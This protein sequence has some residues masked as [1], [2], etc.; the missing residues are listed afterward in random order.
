MVDYFFANRMVELAGVSKEDRVL[1]IGSGIGN[2]TEFIAKRAGIVYAVEIDPRLIRLASMLIQAKN[3]RFLQGDFLRM[4][5]PPFDK[6]VCNPPYCIIS[7]I[8]ERLSREDFKVAVMS[9]QR[10]LAQRM[11]AQPGTG[12]YGRFTILCQLNF[13]V[14][15]FEEI[16]P[17]AFYPEPEVTSVIVR[18]RP[19]K[20]KPPIANG[21]FFAWFLRQAFSQ[22][23]KKLRNAL[24]KPLIREYGLKKEEASRLL[25]HEIFQE[26]AFRL[27][28]RELIKAS[29][30]IWEKLH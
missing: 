22:R 11:V 7:R 23:N 20:Q 24:L 29:N 26:R 15:L 27:S 25:S 9:V 3:V 8:I 14:E 13:E 4:K 28:P 21:E 19:S 12:D 30:F 5:L 6:V 18:L 16:P 2:L 17:S 1:E 10:E